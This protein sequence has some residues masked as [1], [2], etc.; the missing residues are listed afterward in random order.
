MT[1]GELFDTLR[2]LCP[3]VQGA[4]SDVLTVIVDDVPIGKQF[5]IVEGKVRKQSAVSVSNAMACQFH[6]PDLQT[7]QAV[8]A[9]VSEHPNAACSNSAWLPAAVGEPFR[10]VS[11]KSLQE[12][13]FDPEAVHVLDGVKT[14]ARLKR[15]AKPSSWQLVDRDIDAFTPP[16][17][18][19]MP[20]AVWRQ[21]MGQLLPGFEAVACLRAFSSSS[22]VFH[23]GKPVGE[24]NGHVWVKVSDPAL[25]EKVRS[26]IIPRAMLNG[27]LWLKPRMSRQD[28]VVVGHGDTTICDPATWLPGRLVFNGK[29]MALSD[30]L[31]VTEQRFEL[32]EGSTCL[33]LSKCVDLNTGDVLR[34]SAA[35]KRPM[36]I[37]T[38]SQ[39][40]VHYKE[41]LR[42]DTVLELHDGSTV[43]VKEA[44]RTGAKLRCQAPFRESVS[45]A[46]FFAIDDHGTPFVYD[47]GTGVKH[48][49]PTGRLPADVYGVVAKLKAMLASI[50]QEED[51]ELV[52]FLIDEQLLQRAIES[53][54]WLPEKGKLLMMDKEGNQIL[55]TAE[56]AARFGM[57]E[58]F[59]N[60]L[61]QELLSGFVSADAVGDL[62]AQQYHFVVQAIIAHRQARSSIMQVDMFA[63]RP[64]VRFDDGVV[65]ITLPHRPLNELPHISN[66][67]VVRVWNDFGEHFPEW[68]FLVDMMVYSRFIAGTRRR[69]FLWLHVQPDF[70]KA[71]ITATMLQLGLLVTMDANEMQKAMRGDPSGQEP[72]EFL[73]AWVLHVDEWKTVTA[74]LKKLN[75]SISIAAKNRMKTVIPTYFKLFT[76]AEDVVSLT[77]G[78]I[79][80]QFAERFSY[81]T[82]PD[83]RFDDRP[84]RNEISSNRYREC[85]AAGLGRYI[86][87]RVRALVAAGRDAA[88]RE[89]CS[90]IDAFHAFHL[91]SAEFGD[92]KDTIDD[93]ALQLREMVCEWFIKKDTYGAMRGRFAEA[94]STCRVG[95]YKGRKVVQLTHRVISEFIQLISSK[96]GEA[97]MNYKMAE[98]AQKAD[99]GDSPKT[100]R[101]RIGEGRD[102]TRGALVFLD[103]NG[104]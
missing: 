91:V 102:A 36:V 82:A 63:V 84:L 10:M 46:A 26:T 62:M 101:Y 7:L 40:F 55:F 71:L 79:E 97:K 42:L 45:M 18:A 5:S 85:L 86:N 52:G 3:T 83:A 29:P 76:S 30:D 11:K 54:F 41:D 69:C 44:M 22:R 92:Y 59:G 32:F 2:E 35:A 70:G 8:L 25:V 48:L 75:D 81:M 43:T 87:A 12:A 80:K 31:T 66:E 24:G 73:R 6:V 64:S 58:H 95:D 57:K 99:E 27:K 49:L 28:G 47:S 15:Y 103:K 94:L 51:K 4:S 34:H 67:D 38:G 1:A 96:S 98:L 9:V 61:D 74:D 19:A 39:G 17:F 37:R 23:E 100:L 77:Q 68:Q 65:T 90:W 20:F 33:D 78:G 16:E 50:C 53:S 89:A 93:A 56:Q 13:G 72:A 21:A 104:V 14:F 88:D 60:L